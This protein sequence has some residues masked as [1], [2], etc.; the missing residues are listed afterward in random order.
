MHFLDHRNKKVFKKVHFHVFRTFCQRET[1][2]VTLCFSGQQ[3]TL[4][5]RSSFLKG[6]TLLFILQE[7]TLDKRGKNDNDSVQGCHSQG[8]YLENE[9]FSRSGKSQGIC[10]WPGKVKEM[11]GNLKINGYGGSLQKIYLFCSREE[12]MYMYFLMR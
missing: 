7:L 1:T 2:F 8:K 4:Q 12:R 9:V 6:K 3:A 10:G 5:K 11:S